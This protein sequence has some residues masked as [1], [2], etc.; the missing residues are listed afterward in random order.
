MVLLKIN[1]IF[2][3]VITLIK[4]NNI[5]SEFDNTLLQKPEIF[6]SLG[7][8][9]GASIASIITSD[10]ILYHL[11]Y[12]NFLEGCK[13]RIKN[14]HWAAKNLLNSDKRGTHL[15]LDAFLGEVSDFQ[16]TVAEVSQG[17]YEELKPKD[18][19]GTVLTCETPTELMSQMITRTLSYYEGLIDDAKSSGIK[20]EV[21]AFIAKLYKYKYLFRLTE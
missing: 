21:E 17:M 15:Y 10:N 14:M 1:S 18:V 9:P 16:D 13:T 7:T 20:S 5:M 19:C 6:S 3:A 11:T 8:V 4:I 12:I 2:A